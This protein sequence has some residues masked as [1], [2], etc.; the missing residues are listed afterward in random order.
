MNGGRWFGK[1][2][3]IQILG[4]ISEYWVLGTDYIWDRVPSTTM[5]FQH[6]ALSHYSHISIS[7]ISTLYFILVYHLTMM[8]LHKRLLAATVDDR[9]ETSPNE[10]FAVIPQGTEISHGFRD[11]SMKDLAQ[12]VN[13]MCWWIESTIGPAQFRETLAYMGNNDVRYFIFILACQKTGYQV[14]RT[15]LK[16][17]KMTDSNFKGFLAFD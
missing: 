15:T 2:S 13:F 12:A 10:R 8:S 16:A 17:E 14:R 1:G 3:Q 7:C 5:Y 4:L 9:A 6:I 11:L